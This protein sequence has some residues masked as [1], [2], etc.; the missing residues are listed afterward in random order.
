MERRGLLGGSILDQQAAPSASEARLGRAP[1]E[2]LL[3]QPTGRTSSGS[4]VANLWSQM[5]DRAAGGPEKRAQAQQQQIMEAVRTAS[6]RMQAG[7]TLGA[8]E[9]LAPIAPAET[10]KQFIKE[11]GLE[12]QV[13]RDIFKAQ[14][15]P[16]QEFNIDPETGEVIEVFG[17]PGEASARVLRNQVREKKEKPEFSNKDVTDILLKRKDVYEKRIEPIR[18]ALNAGQSIKAIVKSPAKINKPAA[19]SIQYNR[20]L[21][22]TGVL[23]DQERN[24]FESIGNIGERIVSSASFLAT[25]DIPKSQKQQ[26]I[27][28][29]DALENANKA[30]L[31]RSALNEVRALENATGQKIPA[32][33]ALSV[34]DPAIAEQV[35]SVKNLD[36]IARG[37]NLE[38]VLKVVNANLKLG[39]NV[40]F[41]QVVGAL[42]KAGK[43]D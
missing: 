31:Y 19:F 28:A 38:K 1:S 32:D 26:M 7:D 41:D 40:T 27:L 13:G 39:K 18:E 42:D 35:K 9:V 14:Q 8:L 3:S 10:I 21:Q 5:A 23:S 43:L 4:D 22:N 15:T 12:Q 37:D 16:K 20:V 25:G 17:A 36:K 24:A 11:A 30:S 33:K 34:L 6:Q 29:V 2:P